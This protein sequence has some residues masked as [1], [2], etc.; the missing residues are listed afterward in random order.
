MAYSFGVTRP[1]LDKEK[2]RK[3][4]E[5]AKLMGIKVIAVEP[6]NQA[7]WDNIEQLVKEYDIKVAI[8]N[9]NL[10]TTYGNPETVKKPTT[11]I[12]HDQSSRSGAVMRNPRTASTKRPIRSGVHGSRPTRITFG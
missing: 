9:H 1:G 6:Q 12:A 10:D 8:H 2:N 7:A 5:F 11:A 4:F 3:F